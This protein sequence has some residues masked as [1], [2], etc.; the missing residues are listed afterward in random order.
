MKPLPNT[1]ALLAVAKRVVWFKEPADA[2][3][4]PLHFLAHVMT[5]GTVED[6][7][8]VES[9]TGEEEFLETLDH[10]PA[11]VFD[12]RS[13]AYWNLKYGR[14]PAPALPVRQGL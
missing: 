4:D 9:V 10:A 7:R 1:E 11:G 5:Y 2:L 8:V 6:L 14:V 12:P 3:A 13:W